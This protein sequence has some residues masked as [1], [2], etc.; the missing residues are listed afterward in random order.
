MAR[1]VVAVEREQS[2]ELCAARL[3]TIDRKIGALVSAI[4]NGRFS[5]ALNDRLAALE[6]EKAN[7]QSELL[8]G[9]APIVRLHPG[10]AAVYAAKVARLE[11]VLNDPAIRDEANE[12]LRSLIERVEL[13]PGEEGQ[14]MQAVLLAISREIFAVCEAAAEK[15]NRPGR[16]GR[17]IF[18]G[19]GEP[20]PA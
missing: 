9:P 12:L 4:E 3:H 19:C 7:L 6:S 20:Q 10:V 5:P 15:M 8:S 18:G 1:G 11:E 16:P 13:S 14:P 17:F 2:S